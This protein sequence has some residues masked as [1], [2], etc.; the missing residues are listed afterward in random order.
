MAFH[1]DYPNR[2]YV[3]NLLFLA[4]NLFKMNTGFG[5]VFVKLMTKPKWAS[6][7]I[8]GFG[9]LFLL[10]KMLCCSFNICWCFPIEAMQ[11]MLKVE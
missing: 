6:T 4:H 10:W 5:D 9:R 8:K 11:G 7:L 1:L 2:M 3:Y